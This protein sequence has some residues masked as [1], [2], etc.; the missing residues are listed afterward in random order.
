MVL[1]LKS[2]D[3]CIVDPFTKHNYSYQIFYSMYGGKGRLGYHHPGYKEVPDKL[4]RII[5]RV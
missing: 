3:T 1:L 5:K 2:S 4:I